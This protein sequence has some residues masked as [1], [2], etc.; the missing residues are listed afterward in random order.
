MD[1]D[2]SVRNEMESISPPYADN[3]NYSHEDCPY[4]DIVEGIKSAPPFPSVPVN[5]NPIHNPLAQNPYESVIRQQAW[6]I[7]Q[8][9]QQL[10]QMMLVAIGKKDPISWKMVALCLGIAVI[11]FMLQRR[12]IARRNPRISEI[13]HYID[14]LIDSDY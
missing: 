3:F 2:F 14:D 1:T 10:N 13:P 9:Q 4:D 7:R 11:I 12:N 8:Q 5:S 6:L